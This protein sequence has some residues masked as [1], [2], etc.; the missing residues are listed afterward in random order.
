MG[1]EIW[2]PDTA[3]FGESGKPKLVVK[4]DSANGCL[5]K[6]RKLPSLMDL[7]KLF[8]TVSRDRKKEPN[9][10]DPTGDQKP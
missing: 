1:C 5:M 2:V 7:R 10:L 4:S 6:Y 3:I 9:P 8:S